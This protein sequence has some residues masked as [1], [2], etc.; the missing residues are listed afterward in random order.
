MVWN[1]CSHPMLTPNAHTQARGQV[2][3]I[4][5]N[6]SGLFTH[7]TAGSARRVEN[8]SFADHKTALLHVLED[9]FGPNECTSSTSSATCAGARPGIADLGV[10]ASQVKVVGHRVVHG[11]MRSEPEIL[12]KSSRDVIEAASS[13]AP[14]HNAHSLH[15]IDT[16]AAYFPE[17]PQVACFDTAFHMSIPRAAFLYALP[18]ELHERCGIRRYGFHGLSYS[19]AADAVA[20]ALHRRVEDLNLILVHLGNGASMACVRQ[21][22]CIDTSMGLTPLEGLVMGTR[23]GDADLGLFE[24]LCSGEGIGASTRAPMS[25]ASTRAPMS[26]HQVHSMLNRRSGLLGLCGHSDMREVL[27]GR[28]AGDRHCEDAFDVYIHR[29]RKYLGA[30]LLQLGGTCDAIVFTGGV[31]ENAPDVRAEVCRGLDAMGIELDAHRN[32]ECT[33]ETFAQGA[34]EVSFWYS[35]MRV[36]VVRADEEREVALLAAEAVAEKAHPEPEQHVGVGEQFTE[37]LRERT[38]EEEEQIRLAAGIDRYATAFAVLAGG[39]SAENHTPSSLFVSSV[40]DELTCANLSAPFSSVGPIAVELGLMAHASRRVRAGR[41]GYFRPLLAG[42]SSDGADDPMLHLMREAYDISH[43]LQL[44]HGGVTWRTATEMIADGREAELTAE[45]VAKFEQY[46]AAQ[47][48][49]FIL[50]SGLQGQPIQ[51]S[52]F[53]FHTNLGIA[54]ELK[55][56]LVAVARSGA[57]EM[58]GHVRR[59]L[60]VAYAESERERATLAGIIITGLANGSSLG[61]SHCNANAASETAQKKLEHF[62]RPMQLLAA[63]PCDEALAGLSLRDVCAACEAEEIVSSGGID[64]HRCRSVLLAAGSTDEM[65]ARLERRRRHQPQ[66]VPKAAMLQHVPKAAMLNSP[67]IVVDVTRA[68]AILGAVCASMSSCYAPVAGL[69]LTGVS[70]DLASELDDLESEM[71]AGKRPSVEG[72]RTLRLAIAMIGTGAHGRRVPILTTRLREVT[73][74]ARRLARCPP[75]PPGAHP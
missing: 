34:A 72:D 54:A 35:P 12:T 70:S 26:V 9:L 4:G 17:A 66:H 15:G 7:H 56:P 36:F 73:E 6:G 61:A 51:G 46:K 45:V 32:T 40:D 13:L 44:M 14:L 23:C 18:L 63:L 11:G 50:L 8:V 47:P 58:V 2:E 31:G 64:R 68:E 10:E 53:A 62:S 25:V 30:Y 5:S 16:C 24:Y 3:G 42:A 19:G 29:V 22:E 1:S 28:A 71:A 21:G 52:Q 60:G 69:L 67:L 65:L 37:Q 27:A 48:L 33:A 49:E 75:P 59:R 41:V 39:G 57:N 20:R 43:E 38:V 55:T 74:V